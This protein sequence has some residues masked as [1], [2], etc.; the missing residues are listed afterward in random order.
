MVLRTKVNKKEIKH[1]QTHKVEIKFNHV[2]YCHV[3]RVVS[4][5]MK[6]NMNSSNFNWI[7]DG[8]TRFSILLI[9]G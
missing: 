1:T 3:E 9:Y 2:T 7:N 5:H 4:L 8:L 6:R